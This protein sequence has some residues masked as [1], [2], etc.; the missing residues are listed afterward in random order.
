MKALLQSAR[1]EF[2]DYDRLMARILREKIHKMKLISAVMTRRSA[3]LRLLDSSVEESGEI[4]KI[5]IE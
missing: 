4:K 2:D 5:T 3:L 1:A